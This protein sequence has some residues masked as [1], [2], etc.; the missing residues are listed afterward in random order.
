MQTSEGSAARV[1]QPTLRGRQ[2]VAAIWFPRGWFDPITQARRIVAYWQAGATVMRF[3]QGDL[4]RYPAAIELDTHALSGWPLQQA[5]SVLSSAALTERELAAAPAGD[6]LIVLGA[7]ILPLNLRDAV[8]L[9]P[10][11]WLDVGQLTLHET[12]DCT[13][14]PPAPIVLDLDARPVREVLRGTVPPASAEQVGVL[15]ALHKAQ[16]DRAQQLKQPRQASQRQAPVDPRSSA[17]GMLLWFVIAIFVLIAVARDRPG[18]FAFVCVVAIVAVVFYVLARGALPV[19]I[20]LVTQGASGSGAAADT[21]VSKP[22]ERLPARRNE[23]TQPQRWRGW[24]A[25]WAMT[26]QL[27][28]LIGRAQARYMHRMLRLFEEGDLYEALRHAI[29]LGG[30]SVGQS[31]GTPQPRNDLTLSTARTAGAS[32]FGDETLEHHLR[33]LYRQAFNKLDREGRIDEAVFVLAELLDAKQEALDY[34]EK[35][36]RFKQAAELALG[37]D[38]PAE[39][40]VR[41]YCLADDWQ[42]AL[43]VARRDSAFANAVL[44]LEKKAPAV[45]RRLRMEWGVTLTQQGEWLAAVDAIWPDASLRSQAAEWLL[46]AESVGGRLGARALV[47]RA[48][49]LPDTMD[50]YAE[51]LEQLRSD[52]TLWTERANLAEAVLGIGRGGVPQDLASLITP[53]VIADHAREHRRFDRYSLQQ[54]LKLSGDVLLQTDLPPNDWP[55]LQH[56]PISQRNEVLELDSPAP[57]VHGIYDAVPLDDQ[58]YLLALGEAGACVVDSAGRTRAHFAVPAE[59]LV[60]SHSRQVALA[61]ARRESLW[62]VSRIDLAQRNIVDLGV[63][64]F[65]HFCGQFDGLHWT[66]ARGKRLQVLDTQ[67]SLQEVVWQVTDLPGVV[68]A[69][70]SSVHQEHVLTLDAGQTGEQWTY[71]LPQ[72][73]LTAREQLPQLA[74]QVRLLNTARGSMDFAIERVSPDE[75]R[76]RAQWNRSASPF[77]CAVSASAAEESDLLIWTD[78]DWVVVGSSVD[79]RYL[80]RWISPNTGKLHAFVRWPGE[81]RPQA[82]AVGHEWLLFDPGGRL[83]SLNV[84]TGQHHK[85]TVR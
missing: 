34:L 75:V 66:V 3:P 57:G 19:L 70:A 42:R 1:Q 9:D 83:V 36:Q 25:R 29:P 74:G 47:Q 76:I 45:A 77:E 37:W 21:R 84:E 5:G 14:P 10:A 50:I 67:R 32:L 60:I 35:H 55:A 72:R 16:Q 2:S 64:D 38:M 81:S 12:Y 40:I 80:M 53:L 61:L 26:L 39:V 7:E 41:L 51:H 22:S 46:T 17:L 33:A 44:Q 65:T 27:S 69:M 85:I 82:R 11:A 43:A 13:T 48:A 4:L 71:Q 23:Q 28:R 18:T 20:H 68:Y 78:Y 56:S 8:P 6:V 31:F 52:P 54:L 58:R 59:R 24:L 30:E 63:A 79:G 15:K 49:L 73:R 62:R